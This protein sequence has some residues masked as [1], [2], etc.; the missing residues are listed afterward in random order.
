MKRLALPNLGIAQK[1]NLIG[2]ALRAAD[3]IGPANLFEAL[4]KRSSDC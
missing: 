2:T 3:P 4:K 1:R